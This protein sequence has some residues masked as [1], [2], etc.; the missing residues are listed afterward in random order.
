MPNGGEAEKEAR[1]SERVE[2]RYVYHRY[3][4]SLERVFGKGAGSSR[5]SPFFDITDES[6]ETTSGQAAV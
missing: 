6:T 2:W 3:R 4:Q 5:N 1:I